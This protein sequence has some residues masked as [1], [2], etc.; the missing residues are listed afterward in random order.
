MRPSRLRS[1]TSRVSTVN[2]VAFSACGELLAV[3]QRRGAIAIYAK[4]PGGN[5]YGPEPVFEIS[6]PESKLAF[7]DGVAFVPPDENYIDSL[8]AALTAGV[9]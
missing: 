1:V 2:D 6:G 8:V 7:S 5:G 9:P 4:N 3:A